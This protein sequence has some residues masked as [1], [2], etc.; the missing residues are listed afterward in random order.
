MSII[1]NNKTYGIETKK[2]P[3]NNQNKTINAN[4]TYT[5]D[6]DYDGLGTV[7]VNVQPQGVQ[8]LTG[9]YMVTEA[10]NSYKILNNTNNIS[11]WRFKGDTT[12]ETPSTTIS[13][14][15]YGLI[16]IEFNLTNSSI[17]S[18]GQFRECST[19]VKIELPA[20]I[21]TIGGGCFFS[22]GL[23]DYPDMTNVTTTTGDN[24]FYMCPIKSIGLTINDNVVRNYANGTFNGFDQTKV[25]D[26]VYVNGAVYVA[27]FYTQNNGDIDFTNGFDGLPIYKWCMYGGHMRYTLNSLKFPS[28]LQYLSGLAFSRCTVTNLY[29]YGTTPP[30]AIPFESGG[31]NN[32]WSGSNITNIYVPAASLTDY[33]NS[34]AFADVASKIQAMP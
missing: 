10:S 23:I 5:A 14:T 12:W 21:T 13:V 18:S 25:I 11:G 19:L 16:E 9:Y 3:V 27:L 7:T 24:I 29:F 32:I 22:A 20:S 6:Q 26:K 31:S 1:R 2:M 30:Q 4:G 28:T 33:Q 34:S 15:N 17:I 8:Y